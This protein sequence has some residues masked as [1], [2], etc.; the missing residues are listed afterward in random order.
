MGQRKT[1]EIN[2]ILP[3]KLSCTSPSIGMRT[4]DIGANILNIAITQCNFDYILF[5]DG[6]CIPKKIL[7]KF[8]RDML[9]RDIFTWG[10]L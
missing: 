5:T 10:V 1:Q 6:D 7:L 4:K 3:R 2:R 8:T 9:K